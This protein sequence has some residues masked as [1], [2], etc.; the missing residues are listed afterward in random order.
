MVCLHQTDAKKVVHQGVSDQQNE[1]VAADHAAA[2]MH[3][4]FEFESKMLD[5]EGAVEGM[6]GADVMQAVK[7]GRLNM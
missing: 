4:T 3:G 5:L 7:R 2:M 1:Q 6:A